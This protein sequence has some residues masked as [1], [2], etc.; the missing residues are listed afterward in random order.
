MIFLILNNVFSTRFSRFT[1]PDP[2]A[3]RYPSV[4]PYAYCAANPLRY[5]DPTGKYIV[6]IDGLPVDYEKETGW[7]ENT[8]QDM[9]TVGNAMMMTNKVH[10]F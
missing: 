6:G 2:A 10:K 3:D 8:T 4:S 7:S 1:T 9:I 5:S